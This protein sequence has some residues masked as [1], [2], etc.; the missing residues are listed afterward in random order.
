M[1]GVPRGSANHGLARGVEN[2]QHLCTHS[3]A[4]HR[5][6][7]KSYASCNSVVFAACFIFFIVRTKAGTASA[8][9]ASTALCKP[10][11]TYSICMCP[12][13]GHDHCVERASKQN[14]GGGN[15]AGA[16]SWEGRKEFIVF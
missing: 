11:L 1:D 2:K 9:I 13:S 7:F 16:Q 10:C 12:R 4:V 3:E 14:G 5:E 8:C 15:A 6:A